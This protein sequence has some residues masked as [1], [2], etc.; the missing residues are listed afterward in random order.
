MSF[1]TFFDTKS[2]RHL[3]ISC[4]FN[5]IPNNFLDVIRINFQSIFDQFIPLAL[6]FYKIDLFFDL[7]LC[8]VST[9]SHTS[10]S[11]CKK[12][13]ETLSKLVLGKEAF[14]G[15]QIFTQK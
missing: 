14:R 1:N 5:P 13:I 6:N 9:G 8:T 7:F 15:H 11:S 10:F 4:N 2:S 3:N 12:S